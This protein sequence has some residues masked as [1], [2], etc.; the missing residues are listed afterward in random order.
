MDPEQEALLADS[1]GLALLIVLETF[2]PPERLAFV[3]S[4]IFSVPFDEIGTIVER[5]PR[6]ACQLAS[7]ARRRV[8]GGALEPDG[9]ASAQREV[10]DA[11]LAAAREGDFERLVAVRTRRDHRYQQPRLRSL[12]RD[13][14]RRHGRRRAHRSPRLPRQD[15]HPHGQ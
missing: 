10:V 2:S 14:R 4:D 11:F 8:R 12:G 6:G 5:S 3:L 13:P 7:G 1:V 15:D 9:D